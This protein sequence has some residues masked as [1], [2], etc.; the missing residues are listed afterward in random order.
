VAKKFLFLDENADYIS[1]SEQVTC[2]PQTSRPRTCRSQTCWLQLV[3]EHH[4]YHKL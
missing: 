3:Y 4:T 2:R 1:G